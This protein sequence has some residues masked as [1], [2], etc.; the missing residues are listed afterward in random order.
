MAKSKKFK[1]RVGGAPKT[2]A[3]LKKVGDISRG[4]DGR[5]YRVIK[6]GKSQRWNKVAR[7]KNGKGR[8]KSK[9]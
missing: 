6:S 3:T 2:S 8:R 5:N 1:T 9:K 7:V 4:S